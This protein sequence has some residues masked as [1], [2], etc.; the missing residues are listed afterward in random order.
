[1]RDRCRGCERQD[2]R[3]DGREAIA[4]K[5]EDIDADRAEHCACIDESGCNRRDLSFANKT[6]LYIWMRARL[7]PSLRKNLVSGRFHALPAI[8]PARAGGSWSIDWRYFA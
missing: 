6:P 1:P 5:S 4:R 2:L 7:C 3:A 8:V